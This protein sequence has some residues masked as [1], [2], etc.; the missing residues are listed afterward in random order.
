[1]K[2]KVFCLFVMIVS[3]LFM[4]QAVMFAHDNDDMESNFKPWYI[5]Q[6]TGDLDAFVKSRT[7]YAWPFQ[8]KS[9]GHTIASYQSYGGAPYFHHGI[10]IMAPAGTSVMTPTGGKVTNIENYGSGPLYWEVAV[11]DE[12]GFIWQF[13]HIDKDSIPQ[14][15]WNA[16]N[17]GTTVAPGTKVGEIVYWSVV[18][19]GERFHHIHLNILGAGG[20][21]Q[22][23]LL[24]ME[25]LPD[26]V[27]PVIQEIGLLQNGNAVGGNAISG[28]YSLYMHVYDEMLHTNWV[29]PTYDV[30]YTLDNGPQ[31]R[32]WKFDTLPGGA[33]DKTYLH[34]YYVKS[35]VCGN[36]SCRKPVVNLGFTGTGTKYFTTEP[37]PHTIAVT[38]TDFY[39]N[40]ATREFS[41]NVRGI[42][43]DFTSTIDKQTVTFADTSYSDSNIVSWSWN[44]GDGDGSTRQNPTHTYMQE[45]SY[46]VILSVTDASGKSADVKKTVV[47]EQVTTPTPPPTATPVIIE[48]AHNKPVTASG[49]FSADFPASA[50]N[51]GNY[52][53]AWGSKYNAGPQWVFIDLGA[54]TDV[55]RVIIEFFN[56]YF[57]PDYYVGVSND[58]VTWEFAATI[59]GSDGGTES[60]YMNRK[61]RYVGLY[62][63]KGAK[64]VYGIKEFLVYSIDY[65]VTPTPTATQTA[66][67][68]PLDN[69]ILNGNFS[70]GMA[71]WSAYIDPTAVGN[72][73]AGDGEAV[74]NITN[75][76]MQNWMIQLLQGSLTYTNGRSYTV[77][78]DGRASAGRSI[79]VI[80]GMSADP[81]TPYGEKVFTLNTTMQ[82]YS[83]TFMMN[84]ITDTT[85]V[86]E[87]DCGI[88]NNN[89]YID[90]VTLIEK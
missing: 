71:N 50:I 82:R 5:D 22:N 52:N 35:M 63:T 64:K 25:D 89:V 86:L 48:V 12:N 46:D 62:L 76:G 40:S 55:Y 27:D 29:L 59:T 11:T 67:P 41:W 4:Y 81:Y 21:Y 33:S 24:F 42:K 6:A 39:G 32:V 75:G 3:F 9:I 78:F 84:D 54:P 43:A 83:Y 7:R 2:K 30:V 79:S 36:Y 37:G 18:S 53:T 90:N 23:G 74:I 61:A 73:S 56:P 34:D 88:D 49:Q 8:P 13:H 57:S 38:A 87:F 80:A 44:F 47:I 45:G 19:F 26:T 51:D 69:L 60:V 16:Y 31:V 77:S 1:M 65:P 20:E 66:T 70:E 17:N 15:V 58:A 72:I 10:D 85:A 28:N 68:T 14:E